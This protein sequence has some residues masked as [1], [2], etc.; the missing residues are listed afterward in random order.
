MRE[1]QALVSSCDYGKDEPSAQA[2]LQRHS[3][4]ESEMNAYGNDIRR[5]R[6]QADHMARSG[7]D[8]LA[9]V[10]GPF[11]SSHSGAA[12]AFWAP[13]H[14]IPP[15]SDFRRGESKGFLGFSLDPALQLSARCASLPAEKFSTHARVDDEAKFRQRHFANSRTVK[16]VS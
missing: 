13:S 1:K 8:S 2:L 14:G 15:G 6:D 10:S 3:C 16:K 12:T 5:L 9:I 11:L 4:L 7:L